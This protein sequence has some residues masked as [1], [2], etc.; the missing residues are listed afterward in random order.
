MGRCVIV[1]GADIEDYDR[2]RTALHDTDYYIFC[3][4]GLKHLEPLGVLPDLI[5]GDF[6]SHPVPHL[7]VET[8]RLPREK[9]DTDTMFAAREAQR[10][11]FSE[12]LFFGRHRAAAGSLPGQCGHSLLDCRPGH[13]GYNLGRLFRAGAGGADGSFR[14]G[15][16]PLFLPAQ[17]WR[18]GQD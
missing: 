5:V 9:D 12:V 11:G 10:R 2:L 17:S 13:G 6:D 18:H 8:I 3:D 15:R 14:P 4:S 16:L 1:G 7:P